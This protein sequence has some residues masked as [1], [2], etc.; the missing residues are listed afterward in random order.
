MS[1]LLQEVDSRDQGKTIVNRVRQNEQVLVTWTAAHD[2]HSGNA[3][4]E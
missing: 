3:P 1:C 2:I 4:V